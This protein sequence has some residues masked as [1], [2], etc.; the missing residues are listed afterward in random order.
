MSLHWPSNAEYFVPAYQVAALPFLTSS[1]ISRGQIH[2]HDFPL[3]TKFINVV[4]KGTNIGD[5]ICLAFTERGLNPSVG[6]FITLDQGETVHHDI[7]TSVLFISCSA[8]ANVD[9][10]LFCGLTT[11]PIKNFTIL[12]GS[13]GHPGVG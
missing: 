7:R 3:V 6:N 4:N 10:Q 1:I 5:K 13:N 2:T 12:T 8:G 9:Y 11:I